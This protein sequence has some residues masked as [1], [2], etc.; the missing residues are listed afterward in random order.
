[1]RKESMNPEL[2]L[3]G[4]ERALD[5]FGEG[6]GRDGAP[7][8]VLPAPGAAFAVAL[9]AFGM[10]WGRSRN[11]Q[12][13]VGTAVR[14]NERASFASAMRAFGTGWRASA[15]RAGSGV[16]GSLKELGTAAMPAA[17]RKDGY[18]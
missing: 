17:Q 10:A 4:F 9:D 2:A 6:W 11:A 8:G 18:R 14:E 3:N 1:M 16:P 13:P 5:A 7:K 15:R 12:A